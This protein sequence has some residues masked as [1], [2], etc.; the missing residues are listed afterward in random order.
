MELLSSDEAIAPLGLDTVD[1]A[2]DRVLTNRED[3][4]P[5]TPPGLLGQ[6]GNDPKRR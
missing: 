3:G 1:A 4:C 6:Q 5:P 2:V